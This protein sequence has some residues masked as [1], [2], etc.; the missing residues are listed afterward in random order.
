MRPAGSRGQ[1]RVPG[2]LRKR[3]TCTRATAR[4]RVARTFYLRSV[5]QYGFEP[6][7][8]RLFGFAGPHLPLHVNLRSGN[9]SAPRMERRDHPRVRGRSGNLA[10]DNFIGVD[11]RC[12]RYGVGSD[13]EVRGHP[14][15][16]RVT[17]SPPGLNSVFHE[18]VAHHVTDNQMRVLDTS[19]MRCFDAHF[20]L[21]ERPKLPAVPAR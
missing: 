3:P 6:L 20:D 16:V 10:L 2:R 19:H 18:V 12:S 17:R 14:A 7:I 11:D 15:H 21:S 4:R 9:L 5:P 8:A 13:Q 1:G